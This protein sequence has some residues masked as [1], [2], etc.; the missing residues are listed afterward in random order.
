MDKP[1]VCAGL[2]KNMAIKNRVVAAVIDLYVCIFYLYVCVSAVVE[3]YVFY[4]TLLHDGVFHVLVNRL[5]YYGFTNKN[6]FLPT[7]AWTLMKKWWCDK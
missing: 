4:T 1:H 5:G 6:A 3:S 7:Y 2:N